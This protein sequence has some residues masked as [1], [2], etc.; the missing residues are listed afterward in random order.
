VAQ[1]VEH[2]PRGVPS[3]AKEK[4]TNKTT[5]KKPN[6]LE[7]R[8]QNQ[9]VGFPFHSHQQSITVTTPSCEVLAAALKN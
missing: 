8:T 1:V 6:Q 5:I 9:A 2:L 4:Q 3:T 7:S